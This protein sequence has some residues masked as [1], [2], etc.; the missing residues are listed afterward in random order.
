MPL[1]TYYNLTMRGKN[2]ITCISI[3]LVQTK[4]MH[5]FGNIKI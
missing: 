3:K 5:P 4:D 1:G 2:V